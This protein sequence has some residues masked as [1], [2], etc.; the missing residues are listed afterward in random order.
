[1]TLTVAGGT[2]VVGTVVGAAS[3]GAAAV[4]IKHSSATSTV[5]GPGAASETIT[6]STTGGGLFEFGGDADRSLRVRNA[7]TGKTTTFKPDGDGE[8]YA[9]DHVIIFTGSLEEVPSMDGLVDVRTPEGSESSV[10]VSGSYSGDRGIFTDQTFAPYIVELLDG[11]GTVVSTTGEKVYGTNYE[12]EFDQDG[13]TVTITRDEEVDESWLVEFEIENDSSGDI[14]AVPHEDGDD[15]FEIPL[16][17]FNVDDGEYEWEMIIY[18]GP[19]SSDEDIAI[20]LPGGDEQLVTIGAADEGT[21]GDSGNTE[22]NG[23]S[24]SSESADNTSDTES[25]GDSAPGG[26]GMPGFGPVATIAG[27][28]GGYALIRRSEDET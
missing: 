27:L 18:N 24:N 23:D 15:V 16:D 21:D 10:T 7:A 2:G 6:V 8:T 3:S 28:A 5:V 11:S 13:A 9:T 26:D 4:D 22:S 25:N 20:R 19:N 1:M 12:W 17:E 14:Q